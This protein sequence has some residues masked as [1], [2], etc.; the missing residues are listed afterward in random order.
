MNDELMTLARNLLTVAASFYVASYTGEERT[1]QPSVLFRKNGVGKLLPRSLCDVCFERASGKRALAQFLARLFE[2]QEMDGAIVIS[3][4]WFAVANDDDDLNAYPD[5]K[6]R[7]DKVEA[8]SAFVYASASDVEILMQRIERGQLIGEI[9]ARPSAR[10]ISG[11]LIP[12]PA[13]AP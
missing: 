9:E 12:E 13:E 2:K 7:P 4:T 11:N 3:E 8:L 5:V 1:M 10:A 6:S